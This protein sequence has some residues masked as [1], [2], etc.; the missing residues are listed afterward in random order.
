MHVEPTL[1]QYQGQ[2][3]QCFTTFKIKYSDSIYILVY[4]KVHM[5]DSNLVSEYIYISRGKS[6][7]PFDRA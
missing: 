3:V 4:L 7:H 5:L 1:T 6:E 2:A